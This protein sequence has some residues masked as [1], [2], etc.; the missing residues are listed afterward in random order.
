MHSVSIPYPVLG[1]INSEMVGVLPDV[2]ALEPLGRE[3]VGR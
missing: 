1:F 2:L 3:A